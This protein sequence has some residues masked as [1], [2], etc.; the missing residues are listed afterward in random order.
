[1][2][3]VNWSTKRRAKR[4]KAQGQKERDSQKGQKG[5]F[6]SVETCFY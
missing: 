5:A 1:M 2:G 6:L 3:H 4:T